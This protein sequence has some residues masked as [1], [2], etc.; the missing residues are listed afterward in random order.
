MVVDELS[1]GKPTGHDAKQEKRR[2]GQ[3][4]RSDRDMSP[5]APG[6]GAGAAYGNDNSFQAAVDSRNH[7]SGRKH[8]NRQSATDHRKELAQTKLAAH[9]EKEKAKVAA[10]KAMMASNRASNALYQPK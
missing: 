2:M 8:G 6:G 9:Q 7:K 4:A 1:G 5:E 3:M 10:L